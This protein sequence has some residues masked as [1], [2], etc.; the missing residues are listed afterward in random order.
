MAGAGRAMLV[1]KAMGSE[2][3]SFMLEKV[4]G[5]YINIGNG[6]GGVLV[7]RIA[8]AG[9]ILDRTESDLFPKFI[10][11]GGPDFTNP[12][13]YRPTANGLTNGVIPTR[14]ILTTAFMKTYE[15]GILIR[16]TGDIIA[17]SPPL[18]IE[19]HHIDTLIGTLADVL[20]TLD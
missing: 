16:T 19:R 18:M 3:F 1:P 14:A 15:N 9:W 8:G 4:P 5:A 7:N 20:K 17:M 10:R 11:N 12:A 6:E 13:N 2:D